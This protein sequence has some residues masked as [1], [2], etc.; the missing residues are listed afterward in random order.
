MKNM[1]SA[2][3]SITLDALEFQVPLNPHIPS[4]LE[5]PVFLTLVVFLFAFFS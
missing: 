2:L 5:Q 4:V 3:A 1:S